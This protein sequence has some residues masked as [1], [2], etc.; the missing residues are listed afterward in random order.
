MKDYYSV[1]NFISV[2]FDRIGTWFLSGEALAHFVCSGSIEKCSKIEIGLCDIASDFLIE[3]L[4]AFG[5]TAEVMDLHKDI[6]IFSKDGYLVEVQIYRTGNKGKYSLESKALSIDSK[7][8]RCIDEEELEDARRKRQDLSGNGMWR[9][10]INESMPQYLQLPYRYG[11][12]LDTILP[13]WYMSA[14]RREYPTTGEIFFTDKKKENGRILISRLMQNAEEC[15]FTDKLF[16]GFGTCLGYIMFGD[17]IPKD[18]D[19]DMCI[20]S[21]DLTLEQHERYGAKSYSVDVVKPARWEFRKREDNGK[22]LWFSVGYKNPVSEEG[23]K[24]C[25]WFFYSWQ[26][27]L[28]HTKGGAWVN[29]RKMNQ[30]KIQYSIG[31]QAVSLGIDESLIRELVEVPF[32][33]IKIKIPKDAGSC[34][35]HWYPGWN[36][37]GEGASAHAIVSIVG[38]WENQK[39]WRMA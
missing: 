34:L 29:P 31:D 8:I 21:D 27:Y 32:G 39:T 2:F 13:L 37:Q 36:P 30:Q 23:I 28:W 12:I 6:F 3:R 35:D 20:L 22:Y 19:I 25:N 9:R 26:G 18:R 11:T 15:R 10:Q 1:V 7:L 38:K 14:P 4:S 24:S 5:L 33:D 16:A 17:F